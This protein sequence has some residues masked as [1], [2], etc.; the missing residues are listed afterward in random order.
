MAV[1]GEFFLV[2]AVTNIAW[3]NKADVRPQIWSRLI[4]SRQIRPQRPLSVRNVGIVTYVR[5]AYDVVPN[6]YLN[7]YTFSGQI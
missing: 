3:T 5:R 4:W 1:R 2:R 7:Y 6:V